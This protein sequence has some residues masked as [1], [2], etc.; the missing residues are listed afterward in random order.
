MYVF[1]G[2]LSLGTGKWIEDVWEFHTLKG[3]WHTVGRLP[4]PR[5]HHSMAVDQNDVYI[6]GGFGR[7]RILLNTVVKFSVS[8]GMEM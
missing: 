8:S 6:S 2:E 3:L 7:H 4:S 1:G 5:R